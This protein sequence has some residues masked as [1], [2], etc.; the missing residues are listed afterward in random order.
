MSHAARDRPARRAPVRRARHGRRPRPPPSGGARPA[1]DQAEGVAGAHDRVGRGLPRLAQ[2]RRGLGMAERVA[3][4]AERAQHA[5]PLVGARRFAQRPLEL[6]GGDLR[7]AL[8]TGLA[9][10]GGE[11]VDDPLL[12]GGCRGRQMRREDRRRRDPAALKQTCGGAV[13][14]GSLYRRI[15]VGDRGADQR[16]AELER[17]GVGQHVGRGQCRHGR[18]GVGFGDPGERRRHLEVAA[19][20]E[21]DDRIGDRARSGRQRAHQPRDTTG[22]ALRADG[23]Q[24]R[25]ASEA[26]P[27]AISVSRSS[28]SSA[29]PPVASTTAATNSGTAPSRAALRRASPLPRA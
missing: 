20:A 22:D 27:A 1:G 8:G 11:D 12:A 13:G 5:R 15:T 19:V 26:K 28:T 29:L 6:G 17:G 23:L 25:S 2:R 21:D 9:G 4:G 16:M 10:S 3:G 14:G 18:P 24:L 7:R